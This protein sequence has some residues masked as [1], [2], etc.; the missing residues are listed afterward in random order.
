MAIPNPGIQPSYKKYEFYNTLFMLHD[1]FRTK[2]SNLLTV[3]MI[4]SLYVT[5]LFNVNA[6]PLAS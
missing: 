5:D 6:W 3:T 4:M 1:P 2:I